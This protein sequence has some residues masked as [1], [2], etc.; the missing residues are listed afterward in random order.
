MSWGCR[1]RSVT[2]DTACS[3]SLAAVHLAAQSL[4]LGECR[5]ALA[6][7]VSL[8]L[9]PELTINF[10]RAHMLAPDGRCKT[11]DSRA[12]G[13]VRSEGC[14]VL[15]LKRLSDAV[16]AGDRVLALIRG[17]AINHDGRSSG[18]TVPNGPAQESVIREALV[19]AGIAA[20]DVDYV[21]AHGTGT[22]LG[23]PVE[24]RALGNVFRTGRLPDRPLR[25]GSVKTNVGHLEAAAG[26]T[27]LLKVV[28]ALQHGVIPPHLH[29]HEPT[30]HVDWTELALHVP[31]G[32]TAWAR[33]ARARLAGVSAFG[34]SGTNVHVVVGEAA[35]AESAVNERDR[36]LHVLAIS[37]KTAPALSQAASRLAAHLNAT[38]AL[39]DVCYTANAGR[40]HFGERAAVVAA[41][42]EEVRAAL[43]SLAAGAEAPAVITAS[44]RDARPPEVAFLFAGLGVQRVGMGRELF[45]TQPAFRR[46]LQKCDARLRPHLETPLLSV[47][48]PEPGEYSPIEE[49]AYAQPVLFAF[50]YALAE[51][52]RSW[53]VEPTFVLG[54]SLGEDVAACVA[55]TFSLEDGLDMVAARARIMAAQ[56]DAGA[57]AAVFVPEARVRAILKDGGGSVD[58]AAVNGPQ[59]VIVSGP[60]QDVGRLV[61]RFEAEGLKVRRLKATHACHSASMDPV[62]DR[63]E[64]L[65]SRMTLSAPRLG[66]VSTLTGRLA[67][68]HELTNPRYWRRHVRETV[69]F[70]DSVNALYNEGARL[71][72]EIGPDG[73][74][75]AMGRR[76]L[77]APD[78][79]WLQSLKADE[80]EWA[81]MLATLG[82][83]YANGVAV[84]WDAFDR[85]YARTKI[86]L[87]PY[88]FQRERFWSDAVRPRTG[89]VAAV[90]WTPIGQRLHSPALADTVYQ[91]EIGI[92]VWPSLSDHRVGGASLVPASLFVDMAFAADPGRTVIAD[93]KVHAP[94]VVAE[95]ERRLMQFV[96]SKADDSFSIVSAAPV[97]AAGDPDW[98][99]HA[100]GLLPRSPGD[101]DRS[102]PAAVVNRDAIETTGFNRIDGEAFYG[103]LAARGM[104]MRTRFKAV[105]RVWHHGNEAIGEI[106][107]PSVALAEGIAWQ[108]H[109]VLLDACIQVAAVALPESASDQSHLFV[110]FGRL[111]IH[112]RGVTRAWSHIRLRA[113]ERGESDVVVADIALADDAGDGIAEIEGVT[114][115]RARL[116]S[117]RAAAE[118]A[119]DLL[120][121]LAWRA[122][123]LAAASG[124]AHQVQSL[125]DVAQIAEQVQRTIPA[126]AEA[127]ALAAYGVALDRLQLLAT[128]FI[129]GAVHDL[130]VAWNPG[131]V[132][133]TDEIIDRYGVLSRHRRLL[134]RLLRLLADDGFVEDR[135]TGWVVLKALPAVDAA[136]RAAKIADELLPCDAELALTVR[137]GP[138]LAG[139]LRGAVDPVQLLF[140]G[141]SMALLERVYQESPASRFFNGLAGEAIAGVLRAVPVGLYAPRPRS[142]C[143][144]WR[145]DVGAAAG[146]RRPA[147]RIHL[148]GRVTAVSGKRRRQVQRLRRRR[149]PAARRGA[150]AAGARFPGARL[151]RRHCRERAARD[152]Q[153]AARARSSQDA[154]RP[155]RPAAAWRG[156]R[157]APLAR[158]HLR[159]HGRLVEV[160]RSRSAL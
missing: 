135:G 7:G 71:L 139:V 125:A 160:R 33:N 59:Q 92:S 52:W 121:E 25:V 149:L 138:Q 24:L 53:G 156:H 152:R 114:F 119:S 91:S 30:P 101:S 118:W 27:G 94:L 5:M 102:S 14:G 108:L 127:N 1:G 8:M 111:V 50:E 78:V 145:D 120:C 34:F 38:D 140:P 62:L 69:R 31:T 147:G 88:P 128:D 19:R 103:G 93:L 136:G 21:E 12:D 159:S 131:D 76:C 153:P 70:C 18:L 129:I 122:K 26:V 11:F 89:A 46:T 100:T 113:N 72:V 109:P 43:M 85:D 90:E 143:R 133:S 65:A 95:G 144:Y 106:E 6:G 117:G 157:A 105:R 55:G 115:K 79:N 98:V 48:Y 66:V 49:A 64:Q 134:D 84:R 61:A 56:P 45:Q 146:F 51:L 154:A 81:R 28:L 124:S 2:I 74:A 142:R 82:T 155:W 40:A 35:K 13:Y 41:S 123:P 107:V 151:R 137:S 148:Y 77:D 58:M 44:R 112:Q 83:L 110:G 37:A 126:L 57:M 39:P 10:S 15:V 86:S 141:G 42:I 130:G 17:S 54:H 132:V 67:A 9:L 63:I 23:D 68:G 87:P 80:G 4:R 99:R 73:T 20:P 75:T 158:R 32:P 60:R 36:P 116:G 3:S 29:L 150:R 96:L 22:A 97:D 47:L 16:A 104:E